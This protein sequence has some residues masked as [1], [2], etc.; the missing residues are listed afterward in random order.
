MNATSRFAKRAAAA[1]ALSL[2]VLGSGIASAQ[3]GPKFTLGGTTYTK[4][5]WG[6]QR[7]QGA[8]YNFTTVPGEGYGD[9]GQ[10]TEIELFVNAKV[11]RAVEV[12]ARLH[13]RFN[14]N[15][16][17]NFGGFGDPTGGQDCTG[18]GCGEFDPRSNQYVK[19]RGLNITLTPGYSWVDTI[20]IGANDFGMFDPYV[21]GRLRYIDRDNASGLL[22]QGSAA[23]KAFTWD[24]TRI[25]LPRLWAG[26]FFN[27]GKFHASDAAYG[28]QMRY[29]SGSLFDVGAIAQYVSDQEVDTRD[30][31]FDDG[32]DTRFRFK[33]SVVGFKAGVH[34][35]SKFDARA[36]VYISRSSTSDTIASGDTT[37]DGQYFTDINKYS[38]VPIGHRS[39]WSGRVNFDLNDPFGI[40]LSFK[41]EGFRIGADYVSVMAA[42]RESDVLL[43]EGKDA[44]F[45]LTGPSNGNYGIF[46]GNKTRIGY[47]GWDGNAQQVATINVDNDFTDFDEP[48]AET[49]IGWQGVTIVPQMV[50][51]GLDLAAELSLIGYDTNWQAWGDA[52]RSIFQTPYPGQ[53][54]DSGVGHFRSAYAPFQDKKTTIAAL[55]GKYVIEVGKGIDVFAKLKTIQETDKRLNGAEF[56]PYVA[57]DCPGGGVACRNQQ[58]FYSANN[59][60]S[61][62]YGNP[63]VITVTNPNGTTSTG[64]QWKPFDSISDDDRDLSYFMFNLGGGYQLTND[65]YGSLMYAHYKAD[66]KDGN[67]AFQAYRLHELASGDHSKNQLVLKF[68]YTLGGVS[69]CGFEYQYNWGTFT[70]DFGGGYVTQY[71]SAETSRNVGVPVG[72][73]GFAGRFGGWNSLLQRDFTQNRLKAF[74]KVQF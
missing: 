62:L 56:L 43:T 25:S 12:K 48:L 3:D 16:W 31:N 42:R 27:T 9:N 20:S 13:S 35:G 60:T 29:A 21:I 11:S 47:G 67:S 2:L 61:G 4:W 5:L 55:N 8:L 45:A 69:E 74:I 73:P 72:S 44:T 24:L 54:L 57:G 51:G 46:G 52:S 6:T 64:Y 22:L 65:L 7:D 71:A 40:G 10:G 23:S 17:T 70:P 32:Q 18:G 66:L 68:R 15:F 50:I 19:L 28:L 37:P 14:Q 63:S 36:A 39:D 33:N 53:D 30:I 58:R 26:P 38:P 59:S 41:I 34:P 1:A 49:A